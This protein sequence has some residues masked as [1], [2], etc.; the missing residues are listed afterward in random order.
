MPMHAKPLPVSA[1]L[2]SL[3]C[4]GETMEP[5]LILAIEEC[6]HWPS[7]KPALRR[8][9]WSGGRHVTY[10]ILRIPIYAPFE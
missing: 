8:E 1:R 7:S 9:L 2:I 6:P 3:C 10:A 5:Q 4:G